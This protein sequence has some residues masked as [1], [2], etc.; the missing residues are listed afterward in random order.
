MPCGSPLAA[1]GALAPR[2][3]PAGSLQGQVERL[4]ESEPLRDE[5]FSKALAAKEPGPSQR[6]RAGLYQNLRLAE[7]ESPG[8]RMFAP[9]APVPRW[10]PTSA[11]RSI[12]TFERDVATCVRFPSDEGRSDAGLL[13]AEVRCLDPDARDRADIIVRHHSLLPEPEAR[14]EGSQL[15]K[16]HPMASLASVRSASGEL[17]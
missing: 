9:P 4:C 3:D 5:C 17:V 1:F 15:L 7:H 8:P 14:C 11:W 2:F 12:V 6:I 10:R 16:E 13:V